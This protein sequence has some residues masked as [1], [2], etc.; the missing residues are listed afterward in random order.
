MKK[1]ILI[2]LS[3]TSTSYAQI[4]SSLDSLKDARKELESNTE[5]QI[6]E[7]LEA[8]RLK[9]EENRRLKFESLN[10]NVV[11]DGSSTQQQYQPQT[12]AF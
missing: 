8:S 2:V 9:D 1:I 3:F 10:F 11:N 5:Q 6:L 12:E 4:T 7:K